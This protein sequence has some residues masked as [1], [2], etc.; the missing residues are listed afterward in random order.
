MQTNEIM[1]IKSLSKKY[2]QFT[3]L[4]PANLSIMK[5]EIMGLVG[6][7]GAGKTTL[8]KLI[9][10]QSLPTS[11]ELKLF[12]GSTPEG[13]KQARQRIG[14]IVETPSFYR[15]MTAR[16]NLEYYR[17]Q[18]G[19]PGKEAVEAALHE[20]GLTDTGRKRFKDFSLGMKQ[21]L[22]LALALMN[23]PDFLVL[24]EPINGL[25]PMG[26]VE[27]RELLLTLNRE[28]QIT[29]FISCHVLAELQN[30]ATKYAFIDHGKI[31][32]TITAQQL[33]EHCSLFLRLVVD[34]EAKA[35][36][37]LEKHFQGIRYSV[38][39]D[40]SIHIY[41]LQGKADEVTQVLVTNNVRLFSLETKGM[42]L[43]DYFVSLVGRE[44]NG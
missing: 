27:M 5:G 31:I 16:Q 28:K 21:R 1:A 36:A 7:N 23:H 42:N 15:D 41:N 10:G 6:K 3:A 9:T 20:V 33:E 43:E 4:H 17:I 2:G 38:Q 30:L 18:R 35:A 32:K 25:D 44:S 14:A 29:M 8:L 13:L 40:K 19:I 24:D 11:G 37:L 22:G 12:S 26:I 39:P 34:S